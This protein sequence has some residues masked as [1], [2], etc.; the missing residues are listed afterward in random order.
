MASSSWRRLLIATLKID[1]T[2]VQEL[3]TD[4][5]IRTVVQGVTTLADDLGIQVV[6][7]GV[8]TEAQLEAVRDLGVD[9][10]Q[11]FYFA[12]A[13]PAADYVTFLA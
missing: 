13:L 6:A 3:I 4:P 2:F 9:L 1:R 5:K 12:Q 7:E 10:G 11:G 8:E